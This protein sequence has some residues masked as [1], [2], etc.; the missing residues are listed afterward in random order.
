MSKIEQKLTTPKENDLLVHFKEM[1]LLTMSFQELRFDW[2]RLHFENF[3]LNL[4]INQLLAKNKRD[5]TA[6]AE[7]KKK[8]GN[9]ILFY[10]VSL[11]II[12]DAEGKKITRK[13]LEI[14]WDEFILELGGAKGFEA[15]I[16]KPKASQNRLDLALRE[17]RKIKKNW[18]I[19][20]KTDFP[21]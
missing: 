16:E 1:G 11:A 15:D 9:E 12:K 17:F 5:R 20:S 7:T 21:D 3:K 19:A 14:F 13:T 6:G 18:G 8:K 4:K 10:I 2:I